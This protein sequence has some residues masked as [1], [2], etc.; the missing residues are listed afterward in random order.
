MHAILFFG[1]IF[2]VL[3]LPVSAPMALVAG[4]LFSSMLIHPYPEKNKTWLNWLL[5]VSVVGLGFGM[6]VTQVIDSSLVGIEIM[7]AS[8][9]FVLVV[10]YLLIRIMGMS[11]N[12]G[13]LIS[14]GTAICGGSAI[15]A[16]SPLIKATEKE[17][18]ISLAVVFLLNAVALFLFPPIGTYF[19]MSQQQFGL[20]AAIAIHDTSSVVGAAMS[21][22]NEALQ[23]ATSVKLARVLWIIPMS[24]IT[25]V[26][27]KPKG[28]RVKIPWFILVF[29]GIVCLNSLVSIPSVIGE[30]IVVISKKFLIVSLFLVGSGLPLKNL[31]TLGWKPMVFGALLWI[32]VSIISIALILL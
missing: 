31:K 5:K 1:L 18:S 29:L 20:W 8:F 26:L 7:I 13:H 28:G 25:L 30:N 10:G 2:T 22:G 15:A 27:F 19:D 32:G 9:I 11:K 6:N 16:I 14:S 12:V 24:V 23:V 17:I 21:Y 4:V 3:I